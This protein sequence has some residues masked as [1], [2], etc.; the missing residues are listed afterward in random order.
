MIVIKPGIA[1]KENQLHDRTAAWH[2]TSMTDYLHDRQSAWQT[3]WVTYQLHDRLAAL[4]LIC[5][6]NQL[7]CRKSAWHTI[8]M[9]DHMHGSSFAWKLSVWQTVCMAA[10]LHERTNVWQ[11]TVHLRDRPATATSQLR[12]KTSTAYI[13]SIQVLNKYSQCS[14][15]VSQPLLAVHLALSLFLTQCLPANPSLY[16]LFYTCLRLTVYPIACGPA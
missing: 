14:S 10:L 2:T 5:I 7:H 8:C 1:C 16:S 9:T 4:Q 3:I 6:K 13:F 11:L 12:Y 15:C